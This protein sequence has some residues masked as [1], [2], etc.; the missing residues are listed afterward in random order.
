MAVQ[1]CYASEG[2]IGIALATKRAIVAAIAIFY[3]GT[4]TLGNVESILLGMG[5][6]SLTLSFPY[7]AVSTVL[8]QWHNP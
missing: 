6:K 7:L 5:R 1:Q 8:L 2:V 3:S 4:T